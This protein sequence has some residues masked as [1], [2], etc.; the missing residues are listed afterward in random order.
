MTRMAGANPK[1]AAIFG[2][3]D[4]GMDYDKMNNQAYSSQSDLSQAAT[5]ADARAYMADKEADNIV[6]MGKLNAE[7]IKAGA[8]G[9]G[10]GMAGQALGAV[11]QVAG[12]F[13]GGGGF[14]GGSPFNTGGITDPF[15][16]GLSSVSQIGGGLVGKIY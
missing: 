14:G 5:A 1:I 7:A 6:E 12:L 10:G 4:F 8:A 15:N 13:G 11:G 3:G 2:G 9:G 16:T